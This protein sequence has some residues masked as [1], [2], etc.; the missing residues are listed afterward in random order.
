MD[1]YQA[2]MVLCGTGDSL[3][4]HA[5]HWEYKKDP[6]IIYTEIQTLGGLDRV[7]YFL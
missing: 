3:G 7:C 1:K 4:F 6:N 5:G 2:C